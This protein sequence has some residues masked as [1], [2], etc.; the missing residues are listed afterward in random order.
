MVTKVTLVLQVHTNGGCGF[1]INEDLNYIERKDLN[2]KFKESDEECESI[3]I[4]LINLKNL[5]H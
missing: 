4:E 2:F 5:L 1:Y 3:W